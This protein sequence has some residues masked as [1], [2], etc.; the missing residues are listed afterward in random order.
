MGA[1]PVKFAVFFRNL[2]LGRPP[3]P[4]RAALEAAF[5]AAGAAHPCP[6]LTNSTVV[7]EAGTPA[8]AAR[9]LEAAQAA[10]RRA[11]FGEPAA[12]R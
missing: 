8:G 1:G 9:I 3:A 10:L 4:T 11:G 6:F 12:L 7:F 5:A 2:N